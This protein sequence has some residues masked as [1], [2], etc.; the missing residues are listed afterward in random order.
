MHEERTSPI[1]FDNVKI[2]NDVY[3]CT[4]TALV[5]IATKRLQVYLPPLVHII[6]T[7]ET[8]R[9]NFVLLMGPTGNK[10][11][12]PLLWFRLETSLSP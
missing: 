7:L 6:F 11:D 10:V 1:K 2:I 9:L 3:L 8:G 5:W 12:S 4:S